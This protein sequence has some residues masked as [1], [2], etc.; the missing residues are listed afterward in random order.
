MFIP[1]IKNDFKI[2][3]TYNYKHSAPLSCSITTLHGMNDR[4]VL[5]DEMAEWK[6]HTS[7]IFKHFTFF[8]DHFVIKTNQEQITNLIK[9][10]ANA[11]SRIN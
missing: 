7:K 11:I 5:N 8:G 4:T 2:S 10:T 6:T 3:E 1:I 9:E